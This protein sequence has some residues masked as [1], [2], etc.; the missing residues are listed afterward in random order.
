MIMFLLIKIRAAD[1]AMGLVCRR[2]IHSHWGHANAQA[3][4]FHINN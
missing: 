4:M 2:E 3:A 1:F